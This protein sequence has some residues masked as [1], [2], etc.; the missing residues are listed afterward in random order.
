[1]LSNMM[2]KHFS[3]TVLQTLYQWSQWN[4]SLLF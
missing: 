3:K 4:G 2:L 1:M